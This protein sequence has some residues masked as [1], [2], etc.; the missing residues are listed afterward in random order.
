MRKMLYSNSLRKI[1][2]N[3]I[4]G[5]CLFL[6]T[7]LT[8]CFN[9]ASIAYAEDFVFETE[10]VRYVI[11]A[12]GC[13]K[14]LLDKATGK[15]MLTSQPFPFASIKKNKEYFNS[16]IIKRNGESFIIEFGESGI[17]ADYK[18]V[19]CHSYIVIEL[20]GLTGE[21][22]DEIQLVKIRVNELMNAGESLAVRWDEIFTVCLMGLSDKVNTRLESNNSIGASL[23]SEFGMIGQKVAIIAVP[24]NQFYRVVQSV[25]K[26]FRIPYARIDGQWG[27]LSDAVKKSYLFIDVTEENVEEVI[28]FAKLGRF[29]Y[30]MIYNYAWSSSIGSYP[31]NLKNFPYGEAGLKR[32]VDRLHS[33]GLKVGMHMF[34][35]LVDKKDTLVRPKPDKRLLKDAVA[36]LSEDLDDR[37]TEIVT[38]ENLSD[39]PSQYVLYVNKRGGL[40]IQIDEEIIHYSL[41]GGPFTNKFM[42][43]IRGYNG[44]RPALHKAGVKIHHLAERYGYYL[45][46]LRTS[47]KEEIASRIAGLI[48][49]CGFDMVYFDGGES[50][51]ANGPFWY[52]VSQQ[53]MSIWEK[54]NRDVLV[55]GAGW[56]SWTWHIYSRATCGDFATLARKEYMECHKIAKWWQFYRKNFMPSDLGWLGFFASKL[57]CRATLPDEI[58]FYAV[59]SLSLD[60]PLSIETTLKALKENGRTEEFLKMLGKYEE[61][62]QNNSVPISVREKLREGEWHLLE[63]EDSIQFVPVKYDTKIVKIPGS[64]VIKNEFASQPLQF[65]LQVMPMLAELG[66]KKN[67][68]IVSPASP[69]LIGGVDERYEMPGALAARIEFGKAKETQVGSLLQKTIKPLKLSKNRIIAVTIKVDNLSHDNS[70]QP[71]VLNI[72][73]ESIKNKYRDHYIDLDFVGERTI[74]IPESNVERMLS[75]FKPASSN[76]SFNVAEYDFDYGN[77]AAVN[78]RWMKYSVPLKCTVTLLEALAELNT[79]TKKPHIFLG[80]AG[81]VLPVTIFTDDYVELREDGFCK[82][83]D[84]NGFLLSATEPG[85]II[86]NIQ[87]GENK[88]EFKDFE[89]G[90]VRLTAIMSGSPIQP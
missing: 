45:A 62:R 54:I 16:T 29:S 40:D 15:E 1:R 32:V 33:S 53:Q 58:E 73:L 10:N 57:D 18:I 38:V 47:L 11:G 83:Y 34:T 49:R 75:E 84:K 78:F 64:T 7:T 59:R 76:Y 3:L 21:R 37:T 79:V 8:I 70:K 36:T 46:D 81:I 26:D 14:S 86:P 12:N 87:A 48:N 60:T 28:K 20:I 5:Y 61:L 6:I 9:I 89:A 31:I 35:S 63:Q 55:Q 50:N 85:G 2:K 25:E 68:I 43:C 17:Q 74:I 66:D 42:Q 52:W 44:T 69:V 22:I 41:I 23:Y 65:R 51:A 56:T 39:F 72:Q 82:V 80:N 90:F 13:N 4:K 27:K 71:A 19:A 88:I 77:V 24:T 30:V 67:V